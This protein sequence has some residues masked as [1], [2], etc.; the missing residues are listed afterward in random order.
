[1]FAVTQEKKKDFKTSWSFGLF[2][3]NLIDVLV[4]SIF[5]CGQYFGVINNLVWLIF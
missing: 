4:Q 1:M 3:F 5:W 2:Y